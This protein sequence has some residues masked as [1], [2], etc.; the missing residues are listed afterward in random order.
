MPVLR[1]LDL[2]PN[3]PERNPVVKRY[4]YCIYTKVRPPG[5][6]F[7]NY[8]TLLWG[9]VGQLCPISGAFIE[10]VLVVVKM[11]TYPNSEPTLRI[12]GTVSPLHPT[13]SRI[14]REH[15]YL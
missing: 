13:P 9:G 2:Q 7:L 8:V 1:Q 14:E 12:R 5:E 6:S 3:I 11:T 15:I 10:G 4:P